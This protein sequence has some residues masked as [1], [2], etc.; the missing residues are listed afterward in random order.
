MAPSNKFLSL[1]AYSIK[2]LSLSLPLIQSLFPSLPSIQSLSHS[3]TTPTEI[4]SPMIE[5]QLDSL[6]SPNLDSKPPISFQNLL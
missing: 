4:S 5:N 6:S 2:S 3:Q 1:S